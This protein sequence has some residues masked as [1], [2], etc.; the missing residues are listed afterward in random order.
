MKKIIAALLILFTL[1]LCGCTPYTSRFSAVGYV[2]SNTSKKV[3]MSFYEFNGTQVFNL[4]AKNSDEHIK[5]SVKLESGKADV[6]Y[7][8]GEGKV[9]LFT[10]NGGDEFNGQGE[11]LRA[12]KVYLI[13]ET[14]GKCSNGSFVFTV[15]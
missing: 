6:Y 5:Y 14:D 1:T 12:G 4:K 8:C 11:A 3:D 2:H 9:L 10:I 7:D 15:E 13:V